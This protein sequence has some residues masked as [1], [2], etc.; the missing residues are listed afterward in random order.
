MISR[1]EFLKRAGVLALGAPLFGAPAVH[2]YKP[3][4]IVIGAGL[5]GLAAAHLLV[6]QGWTVTVLEARD[7]W[8]GRVFTHRMQE[9]PDLICELGAEWVGASHERVQ[10]LCTGFGI[11]LRDHRFQASL[12]RDGVVVGPG[13][14]RYSAAAEAGFERLRQTFER[15]TIAEK[16]RMDSM[17]WWTCLQGVGFND[18]DLR[19]RDLFDSTDFGESI[20]QVSAY[21][22]ATEYFESSPDNEMDFKMEGGN[23]RLADALVRKIGERSIR[24]RTKVQQ[25]TQR[26]GAV[27]VKADGGEFTGDACI[28]TV[29][30]RAL[31]SIR[32]DPPLPAVQLEAARQLQYAR[33]IKS[34]VLYAERFWTEEDF[35]LVSDVTSHYYFNSTKGQPGTGG[36]FTSY[37]I[38]DK[39]DV[40]AA[41]SLSRRMEIIA[42]DLMPVDERAPGLARGIASYPWQ[43]DDYTG[44]AYAIY[45]PGQWFGIR[46]ILAKPHGKVLFAG[47]HLADW[48]GFMEG[49]VV[50]GEDAAH[51]L[52]D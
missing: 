7:R 12:L 15:Y 21:V 13:R 2:L 9:N 24:L 44:G 25:I 14:W 26:R 51:A 18:D 6:R 5:S 36:I 28:C 48:Q 45:R 30:T 52:M 16:Q 33:I 29:P 34:S 11:P 40:L 50:T 46:P 10:A 8:G 47:E 19:L 23:S 35:S 20:R 49:A 17:D 38:G 39:A 3:S 32:F 27:K 37:A 22:A 42:R 41:Q 4:C 31:S 43:R 1:R